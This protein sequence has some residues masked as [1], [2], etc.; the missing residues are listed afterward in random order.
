MFISLSRIAKYG[1]LNFWRNFWLSGATVSVMVLMLFVITLVLGVNVATEHIA[2][3][4][5][6]KVDIS[7]YFE[8]T[9]N[10]QD[11]TALREELEEFSEVKSVEYTSREEALKRFKERHKDDP[12]ILQAIREVGDNPLQATLNVKAFQASQYQA[13]TTFLE[14]TRFE[15]LIDKVN[16][17]ENQSLI[18]RLFAISAAIKRVG[19]GVTML[20]GL[21]AVLV[22][23]NAIRMAIYSQ[24]EEILIMRLVGASNW[25]IRSPFLIQGGLVGGFSAA[26]TLTLTLIFLILFSYKISL[27]IPGLDLIAYM[28][29]NWF[30]ILLFEFLVGI[31]LGIISSFI[32]VRKY[33]RI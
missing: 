5:Q 24:R 16:Y 13:I 15:P 10:E 17:R 12:L 14:D 25:F 22:T 21:I 4:L 20:L 8:T 30:L 29:T 9:A 33:L 28:K 1:W 7:V 26:I 32:A 2:S 27:A 3:I 18:N 31:G 19:F 6:D 23:F 11:I